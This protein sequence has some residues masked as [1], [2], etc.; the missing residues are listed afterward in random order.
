MD[1]WEK[2]LDENMESIRASY[3]SIRRNYYIIMGIMITW[4][5][6]AIIGMFQ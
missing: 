6:S 5:L 3:K 1:K 2:E 4:M